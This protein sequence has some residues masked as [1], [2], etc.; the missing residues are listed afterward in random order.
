M[1]VKTDSTLAE[2]S[3]RAK[4]NDIQSTHTEEVKDANNTIQIRPLT[5]AD[6]E[7]LLGMYQTFEPLGGA[8]GLPPRV[9]EGRQTW[10][11]RALQREVNVGAFSAGGDLVG[12]SFLASS[13]AGEAEFGI[14]VHQRAR[15]RG[16]GTDLLR[17]V[18]QGAEQRG[19]RRIHAVTTYDNIPKL[20]L[21]KRCGFRILQSAYGAEVLVLD[22][23]VPAFT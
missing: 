8:Q 3:A 5:L 19:L 7:S 14:F 22:L 4:H 13:G 2:Q 6:H 11:D 18:L 20:R 1:T 10:I 15:Q 21:L 23:P 17:A 12:H 9:E 16:I